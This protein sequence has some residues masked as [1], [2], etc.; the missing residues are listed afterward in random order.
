M[1]GLLLLLHDISLLVDGNVQVGHIT[2][3]KVTAV[4]I[5]GLRGSDIR[6]TR[7]SL[8]LG[9]SDLGVLGIRAIDLIV[10]AVL[11]QVPELAFPRVLGLARARSF[12]IIPNS[13]RYSLAADMPL[14]AP[15]SSTEASP[16][17][18]GPDSWRLVARRLPV[19]AA[20]AR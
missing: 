13:R 11:D 2:S 6:T 9:S 4:P 15:R 18:A 20:A 3:I 16:W 17:S 10:R 5:S 12:P 14:S 8:V 7:L 19:P 1:W